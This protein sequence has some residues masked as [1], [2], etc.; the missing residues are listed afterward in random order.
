MAT[1]ISIQSSRSAFPSASAEAEA[2]VEIGFAVEVEDRGGFSVG[3]A[4]GAATVGIVACGGFGKLD[5]ISSLVFKAAKLKS[6]AGMLAMMLNE[7]GAETRGFLL[8]LS[9]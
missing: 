7:P 6:A 5:P 9:C 4:G 1:G 2:G 3:I 8:F